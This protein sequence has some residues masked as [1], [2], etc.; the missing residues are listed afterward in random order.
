KAGS[1]NYT[2]SINGDDAV[3]ALKFVAD[4]TTASITDASLVIVTNNQK[5]D[6][7]A[8]NSVR[9]T[10]VDAYNNPVPGIAVQFVTDHGALPSQM[11]IN[12]DADGNA[13]FEL[14]NT[15]A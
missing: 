12:T 13:L 2:F 11:Q 14:T 7:A 9:A 5:A 8:A 15:R 3:R 6:G 1:D 4:E 10:I